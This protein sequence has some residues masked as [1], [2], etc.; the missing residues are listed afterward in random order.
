MGRLKDERIRL[1][2]AH[3]RHCFFAMG[4]NCLRADPLQEK[5]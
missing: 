1:S 3:V 4:K 5:L 2:R